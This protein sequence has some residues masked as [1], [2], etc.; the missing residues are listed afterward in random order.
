MSHR[1]LPEV[2]AVMRHGLI[3][4]VP[5]PFNTGGKI[6]L[7][8]QQ[9]YAAYMAEQPIAG[10]AV[11]AHTG[12]GLYLS[13]SQRMQVLKSWREA[14]AP[15]QI[16]VAGVGALEDRSAGASAVMDCALAMAHDALEGGAEALLVH[17]P[18]PFRGKPGEDELILDYH[19]QLA[20]LK[21]PLVL[22]YLYEAAGGISYSSRLLRSLLELPETLGIK[23][24]T[25]DSVMTFQEVSA[26]VTREFPGK[27]VI[28][29]EDR[30][31]GYS[32]MC[33]AQAALIGMGAVCTR[34]QYDL[35]QSHFNGN[36]AT[37]L[38]ISHAVDLLA[39]AIFVSPME[40]YIR[41]ILW[42]LVH[43]GVLRRENAE[44]PWGPQLSE[45][46]FRQVGEALRELDKPGSQSP[47]NHSRH[48]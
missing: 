35:M 44:D 1:S 31:L 26:L 36:A 5:V 17:P 45:R 34:L 42:A 16:L 11:W 15:G 27:L 29:G 39:Q 28:T 38:A 32:L 2:Q 3:P 20:S 47:T 30:F 21:A 18:S 37:F 8:S 7:S 22:F 10:V 46:E 9:H 41:R 6:D 4:A 12:R 43:S 14:L 23:L 33:G 19:R 13:R 48:V 24:A 40:G 25:L